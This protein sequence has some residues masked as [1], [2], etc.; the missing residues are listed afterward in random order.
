LAALTWLVEVEGVA[1]D[2]LTAPE[3]EFPTAG[4]EFDG[5]LD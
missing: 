5:V 2:G 1:A 4:F 3:D